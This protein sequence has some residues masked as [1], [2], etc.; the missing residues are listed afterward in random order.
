MRVLH[1][2]GGRVL[3]LLV[4][5]IALYQ[6]GIASAHDDGRQPGV[7]V[8]ERMDGYRGVWHGQEPTK[9]D[10]HFKYSGGLATYTAKHRPLAIYA[11]AVNK[12]FFVFGGTIGTGRDRLASMIGVYDHATG[13]V[14]Q[15]TLVHHKNTYDPHDNPAL[16]IDEA[17]H[18]WIFIS[19]RARG[20]AGWIYRSEKP[21][22]IDKF[23]LTDTG[24]YT[25]PQPWRIPGKGFFFLFTKYLGGRQLFFKK[26]AD[27]LKWSDD[28]KLVAFGGHYQ[29]SWHEGGRVATAFNWHPKGVVDD[30]TNL[31][32][33]E[34]RDLGDS[35]TTAAG[36]PVSLPLE[37][38]QNP[39]L[40]R[41]Y[42]AE[43]KRVYMKDLRF[44]AEGRPV[45][46][47]IVSGGGEPGPSG[48]PRVWTV[49][50]HNGEE[51]KFHD[52]C[53]SD[54]NYDMGLLDIE[55]DHWRVLGPTEPG[56]RPYHT[57]GEIALWESDDAGVTWSKTRDV[58]SESKYAHT[59]VRQVLQGQ[60]DFYAYWADGDPAKMS[61]CHL[62]FCDEKCEQV[63]QLPDQ[64]EG[65]TAKPIKVR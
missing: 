22:D 60:P 42:H 52:V 34:T 13:E 12:T 31:Y 47:V 46:L 49:V 11:P 57:G 4:A 37:T 10:Y 43:G 9:D 35:W 15:P 32:Y 53:T 29:T 38:V 24:E 3:P 2:V 62:Y 39:C 16:S 40:V 61:P 33:V 58:T 20:R 19:G 17:G 8:G 63:W 23:R 54:H 28:T 41:D 27:G 25:Y 5:V 18:L 48:D 30:R 59:Y 14:E 1:E 51:W 36:A 65:A 64:M 6:V 56:P 21:Y 45:M 55:G 44:D 26:S 7:V 50:R